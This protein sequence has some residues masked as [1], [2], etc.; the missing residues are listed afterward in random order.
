MQPF[1]EQDLIRRATRGDEIAFR[2]LVQMHQR[3]VYAVAYRFVGNREEAKDIAQEAW[4]RLWKNLASYQPGGKLTTWFYK[5]VMNL[6]L[7]HLKSAEHKRQGLRLEV[8][9]TTARIDEEQQR[10]QGEML[11][12]IVKFAQELTPKQQSV[13]VLRDLEGLAPEEVSM[14]TGLDAGQVKSNLYLARLAVRAGL[15]RI[16]QER[17]N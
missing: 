16:Y 6:C 11:T 7:D 13:F 5:I 2:K 10:D 4:V 14:I 17:S 15:K 12:F 3:F 8:T 9:E 1:D